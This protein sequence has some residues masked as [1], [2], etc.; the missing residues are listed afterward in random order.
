[1]EKSKIAVNFHASITLKINNIPRLLKTPMQ[2]QVSVLST[3][4]MFTENKWGNYLN[5]VGEEN[6][7]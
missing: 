2:L 5:D 6:C 3:E 1:M 7:Q 4:N